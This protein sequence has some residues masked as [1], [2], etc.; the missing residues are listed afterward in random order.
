MAGSTPGEGDHRPSEPSDGA[1][2]H[3]L[4]P[5]GAINTQC[6]RSTQ[7]LQLYHVQIVNYN[8]QRLTVCL[9][10]A[11]GVKCLLGNGSLYEKT[12][13]SVLKVHASYSD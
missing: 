6:T 1:R 9:L 12:A 3:L 7:P 2:P 8:A 13:V 11:T 4:H 5:N 10:N